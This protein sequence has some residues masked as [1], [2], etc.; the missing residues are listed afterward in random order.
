MSKFTKAE[1]MTIA[2]LFGLA[3]GIF[4]DHTTTGFVYKLFPDMCTNP[5]NIKI[6]KE[7]SGPG[8]LEGR[9]ARLDSAQAK[10]YMDRH[11]PQGD[12][13]ILEVPLELDI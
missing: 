11:P 9:A 13:E 5:E 7:M 1:G 12:K 3:A 4:V 8:T 10:E 2:V 6:A